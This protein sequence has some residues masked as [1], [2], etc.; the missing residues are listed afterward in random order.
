MGYQRFQDVHH[1][2]GIG[3]FLYNLPNVWV[4]V[5]IGSNGKV[6]GFSEAGIRAAKDAYVRWLASPANIYGDPLDHGDTE[7]ARASEEE[8]PEEPPFDPGKDLLPGAPRGASSWKDLGK[9]MQA[10]DPTLDW[11]RLAHDILKAHFNVQERAQLSPPQLREFG[12]RLANLVTALHNGMGGSDFPPP[13]AE[14][15][16]AVAS[17]AFDGLAVEPVYNPQPAGPTVNVPA[18]LPE[19][20][21]EAPG[22]GEGS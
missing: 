21:G 20:P 11:R 15:I 8:L 4:E 16:R 12:I 10:V 18:D 5:R 1:Q 13:P 2:F 19:W 3:A 7:E 9:L 22:A 14:R 6:Q 17:W